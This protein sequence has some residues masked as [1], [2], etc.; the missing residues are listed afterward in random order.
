M[1]VVADWTLTPAE[2]AACQSRVA[3]ADLAPGPGGS[4]ITPV[5]SVTV[6]P[7]TGTGRAVALYPSSQLVQHCDPPIRGTRYHVPLDVNEDC[8][9]FHAGV[10]QQLAVGHVYAM[11]PTQ[12]HGAVNWGVSRRVHLMVDVED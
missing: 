9:V 1:Y 4:R 6:G 11:D 8:W 3:A 10:W 12:P 7:L 5:G 2:V